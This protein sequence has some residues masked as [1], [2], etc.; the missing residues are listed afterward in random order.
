MIID[1]NDKSKSKKFN[2]TLV[3]EVKDNNINE[4][5]EEEEK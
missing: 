3:E 5:D 4:V 1:S 2:N